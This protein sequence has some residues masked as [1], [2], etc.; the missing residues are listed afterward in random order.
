[1]FT[2]LCVALG[3]SLILNPTTSQ[4]QAGA[5]TKPAHAL[6]QLLQAAFVAKN[7]RVTQAKVIELRSIGMGAGPYILLGHGIRPDLKF[8]GAFDDELF[9]VF[10]LD[11]N[12]TRIERTVDIFPT[13]RWA[14]C[15]VSIEKISSS[16]TEVV[17]VGAGSYGDVPFRKVYVINQGK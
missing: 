2:V 5:D 7:P 16:G 1:M 4:T 11:N 9:G 12:L 8:E 6:E 3:F 14:D 10:V 15:F 17:V 13:C